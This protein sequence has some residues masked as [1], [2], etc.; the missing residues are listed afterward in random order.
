LTLAIKRR[1]AALSLSRLAMKADALTPALSL[2]GEGVRGAHCAEAAF[3]RHQI[4][5]RPPAHQVLSPLPLE[6]DH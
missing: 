6:E 3:A 5:T 4:F 2:K 1:I